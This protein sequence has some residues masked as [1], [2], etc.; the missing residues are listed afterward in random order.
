LHFAAGKAPAAA[1][2]VDIADSFF[3]DFDT[4]FA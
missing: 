2:P 1:A 4:D 3:D